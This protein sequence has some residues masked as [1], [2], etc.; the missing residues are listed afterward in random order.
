MVG[1][2]IPAY[3]VQIVARASRVALNTPGQH[4]QRVI[5]IIKRLRPGI[6]EYL[7]GRVDPSPLFEKARGKLCSDTEAG[8]RVAAPALEGV[9]GALADAGLSG[10]EH[11]VSELAQSAVPGR[12]V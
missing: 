8:D 12:C 10:C 7:A 1:R 11:E 2:M 3:P 5:K 9:L 4:R 6:H